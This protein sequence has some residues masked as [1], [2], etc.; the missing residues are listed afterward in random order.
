M[1]IARLINNAPLRAL[2]NHTDLLASRELL[3]GALLQLVLPPARRRRLRAR[4]AG[5]LRSCFPDQAAAVIEARA[6]AFLYHWSA[7]LTEDCLALNLG[8]LE[9]WRRAVNRH[10]VFSQGHN[11]RRALDRGAGILAVGCHAGSISFCTN[12]LLSLLQHVPTHRWPAAR[13]CAEPEIEQFPHVLAKVE[14]VMREYGGDI[15]F[16]FTSW[17]RRRVA[18]VMTETLAG[19]GL[20][21][22]NLDVL[23]GGR[24]QRPFPM[25]DGRISIYLPALVGA[26]RVALATGAVVL[27]WVN[28]RTAGGF[29]LKVEE[30]IGPVPRLGR[31]IPDDHPEA[32]ALCEQLRGHL[33]RWIRARP[34]QWVYWDR[35][36]RRLARGGG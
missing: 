4:V 5:H 19:G 15:Q 36:H 2:V 9:Q 1:N 23:M 10:V 25:F 8:D 3:R 16:I 32:L 31:S 6:A 13:I 12:A 34:E 20:V 21:T 7:K 35:F 28:Y 27:P 11:L 14:Q 30:P 29:F 17:E 22:T 26:A 24:S 18:R 33:E